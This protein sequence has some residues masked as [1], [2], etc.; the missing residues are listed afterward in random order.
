M[1]E[2]G[3]DFIGAFPARVLRVHFARLLGELRAMGEHADPARD[4]RQELEI[5]RLEELGRRRYRRQDTAPYAVHLER[6]PQQRANPEVFD[7]AAHFFGVA[8]DMMFET[9]RAALED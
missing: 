3:D 2:H 1:G 6:D 4:D 5:A 7:D 8:V 9:A